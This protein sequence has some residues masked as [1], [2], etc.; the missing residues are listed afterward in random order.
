MRQ[1]LNSR[2]KSVSHH[3]QLDGSINELFSAGSEVA[4]KTGCRFSAN[5]NWL[6]GQTSRLGHLSSFCDGELVQEDRAF[7]IADEIQL[8]SAA[9]GHLKPTAEIS[10]ASAVYQYRKTLAVP[11][12]FAPIPSNPT[13]SGTPPI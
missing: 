2:S 9:D 11:H 12:V 1:S 10:A 8:K 13:E 4:A 6:S 7:N 3:P 5:R